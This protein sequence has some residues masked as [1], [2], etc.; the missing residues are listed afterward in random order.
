MSKSLHSPRFGTFIV[1][2]AGSGTTI[3]SENCHC[4]TSHGGELER[5]GNIHKGVTI[6]YRQNKLKLTCTAPANSHHLCLNKTH[7]HILKYVTNMTKMK[8][9]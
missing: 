9:K 1:K 8:R 2:E 5:Q 4:H 7:A 6:Y 3:T